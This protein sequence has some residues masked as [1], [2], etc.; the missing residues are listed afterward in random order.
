MMRTESARAVY[1]TYLSC[2]G[3]FAMV[4]INFLEGITVIVFQMQE[5]EMK[6]KCVK[7]RDQ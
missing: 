6:V 1:C 2:Y 7:L 4:L 3:Y 5:V